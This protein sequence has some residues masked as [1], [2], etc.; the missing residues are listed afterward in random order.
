MK[1]CL[2]KDEHSIIMGLY[3]YSVLIFPKKHF[4]ES[5]LVYGYFTFL[6]QLFII[7]GIIYLLISILI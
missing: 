5:Q 2:K 4:K 7:L 6:V 3:V 1:K